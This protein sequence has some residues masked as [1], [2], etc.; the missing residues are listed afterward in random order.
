MIFNERGGRVGVEVEMEIHDAQAL[1]RR[2]ALK[3]RDGEIEVVTLVVPDTRRNRDAMRAAW[4]TLGPRFPADGRK[5]SASWPR[6]GYRRRRESSGSV[7]RCGLAAGGL[8]D[9]ARLG[10]SPAWLTHYLHIFP[11]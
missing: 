1:N 10:Q 4:S 8:A 5:S 11:G 3:Q 9:E 2:I 7:P 6:A